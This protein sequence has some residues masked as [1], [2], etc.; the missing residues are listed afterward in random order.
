MRVYVATVYTDYED[1]SMVGVFYE[2]ARA[3]KELS[4]YPGRDS[5]SIETYQ[6][7]NPKPIHCEWYEV[8]SEDETIVVVSKQDHSRTEFSS[9]LK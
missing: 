7:N 3:I 8:I 2:K 4:L 5:F 9:L 6:I 1:T